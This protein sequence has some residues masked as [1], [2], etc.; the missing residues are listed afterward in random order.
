MTLAQSQQKTSTASGSSSRVMWSDS[1][2]RLGIRVVIKMFYFNFIKLWFK[3]GLNLSACVDRNKED[4]ITCP[5]LKQ[6][7][8]MQFRPVYNTVKSPYDDVRLGGW[9]VM[10]FWLTII[11][12]FFFTLLLWKMNRRSGNFPTEPGFNIIV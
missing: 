2:R 10:W 4:T 9:T 3:K 1:T 12:D 11:S 7:N 6:T 8:I 5:I